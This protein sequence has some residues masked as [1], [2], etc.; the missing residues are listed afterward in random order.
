M[1]ICQDELLMI[2]WMFDHARHAWAYIAHAWHWVWGHR[3]P[4]HQDGCCSE[5][6]HE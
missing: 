1:H 3:R 4:V 2:G 6:N 5:E